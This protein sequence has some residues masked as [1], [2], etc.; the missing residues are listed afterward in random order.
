M[1]YPVWFLPHLNGGLLIALMSVFHVFLAHFA[2]GGGLFLVLAERKG[3]REDSRPILDYV[4]RH[5]KFFLLLTMVLG[6]LTGVGIWFTIALVSP[7]PT[8][9]LIH[10]FVFGWATEWVF[11]IG[12]ITA[13]LIYFYY[14]DKLRPRDHQIVG[15]LYFAFA[16]L[17]LF[18]I[19]GIVGFMLTPGAWLETG[20]FWDGFFNP[21]FWP[22]LFFRSFLAFTFAGLFAFVTAPWI[23]E[24]E[25]REAMVRWSGKWVAAPFLLLLA[26]GWWYLQA[27]P[28]EQSAMILQK[29]VQTPPFLQAFIP[30]SVAVLLA[31][32]A[33]AWLAPNRIRKPMACLLLIL[34][35]TQMGVF[36]WLRETARRPY[37][38]FQH[39]W[40]NGIKTADAAR[41]NQDGM[42]SISPW[43]GMA[44]ITPENRLA[45]GEYLFSVECHNCHGL[46]GPK[47]DIV[48]RTAKF[49]VFGMDAQL[50]GQ[51]ALREYM[52][53]FVGA[54]SERA[55]LASFLVEGVHG[56]KE[57]APLY[58]PPQLPT[59]IPP[60]NQD[61]AEYVL[62]SWNNLGMHCISDSDPYWILLPPANDLFA[63]LIRRGPKPQVVTAGVTLT[64]HVEPGFENPS[65]H[66]RFWEFAE[67]LFGKKLPENVGLAG[68]GVSG[69]MALEGG[70]EGVLGQAGPG[71]ALS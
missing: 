55:A 52:P 71:G 45:A 27:M 63:Q 67:S 17:S 31:G 64:Y 23:P 18:I 10:S 56:K 50:N 11:F 19:N 1:Q 21:S 28:P 38:I 54:R 16:W 58:T 22:A 26:S 24:P 59:E 57:A 48:P 46:G 62:L 68:N 13:L 41:L 34:G 25:A 6:G 32:S 7:G 20:N 47:L 29:S 43:G 8:S 61:T 15:W 39:T 12:E 66:V 9:T 42:L 35:L 49:T 65:K 33:A 37:V 70:V 14:F 40:S 69:A 4:K 30:V 53:P 3:L 44:A 36:E 5:T 60:F 51:G 2:V